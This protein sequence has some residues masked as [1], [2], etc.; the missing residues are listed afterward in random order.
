MEIARA[1]TIFFA[2]LCKL[3]MSIQNDLGVIVVDFNLRGRQMIEFGGKNYFVLTTAAL[4]ANT[5]P[6]HERS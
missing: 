4:L 5:K 2:H 3:F 1:A 6:A